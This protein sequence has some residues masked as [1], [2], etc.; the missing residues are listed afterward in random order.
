MNSYQPI[1]LQQRVDAGGDNNVFRSANKN[2]QFW[3]GNRGIVGGLKMLGEL[4][5]ASED[6]LALVESGML[7]YNFIEKALSTVSII[8]AKNV[9]VNLQHFYI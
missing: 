4:V 7:D 2:K 1:L 9:K 3:N 6:E 5:I 8:E